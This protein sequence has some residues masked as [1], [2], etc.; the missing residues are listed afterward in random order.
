MMNK[1]YMTA[2]QLSELIPYHPKYINDSLKDKYLLEGTHYVRPFGGKRVL[3]IWE[4]VE[5]ALFQTSV[6]KNADVIPMM[7]GGACR[8]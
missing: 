1:T 4:E 6:K 7:N 8:G 5:K 3:Y 2:T